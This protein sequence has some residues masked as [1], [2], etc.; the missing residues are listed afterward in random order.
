MSETEN[1]DPSSNLGTD[2][3]LLSG[4]QSLE[5]HSWYSLGREMLEIGGPNSRAF[6]GNLLPIVSDEGKI[7]LAPVNDSDEYVTKMNYV[8]LADYSDNAGTEHTIRLYSVGVHSSD[9]TISE[10]TE[11][12]TL[13]VDQAKA[14]DGNEELGSIPGVLSFSPMYEAGNKDFFWKDPT[15]TS[16]NHALFAAFDNPGELV[17]FIKSK[18]N[19]SETSRKVS[20]RVVQAFKDRQIEDNERITHPYRE[21]TI[22]W[23]EAHGVYTEEAWIDRNRAIGARR[24]RDWAEKSWL[25]RLGAQIEWALMDPDKRPSDPRDL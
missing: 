8:T 5:R 9:T 17:A 1:Q 18:I 22:D 16:I 12:T 2:P 19:G 13:L 6:S 7:V 4:D 20:E 10:Y 3:S 15:D 11:P 24:Q 21:L 23:W 25:G 14:Q